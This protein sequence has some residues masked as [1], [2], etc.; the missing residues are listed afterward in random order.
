MVYDHG[1]KKRKTEFLTV[2]ETAAMAGVNRHTVD[3]WVRKGWL[4]RHKVPG[5]HSTRFKREDVEALIAP[6]PDKEG[7]PGASATGRP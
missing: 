7:A 4:E 1:M 6:R 5:R 3:R 2:A